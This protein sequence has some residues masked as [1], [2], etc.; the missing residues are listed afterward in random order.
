MLVEGFENLGVGVDGTTSMSETLALVKEAEDLGFHSFWLSEG[1]HSRSA[2]V[3]ATVIA[4]S[5]SRIRIGLGILSPHTKHPALLAMDAAS[6]D[7]VARGRLIL[8]VGTVKNALRKHGF[9]RVDATQVV[10]E[11]IDLL[12][13]LLS[14]QL[15][16]YE[17]AKF[18]IPSPGSRLEL[19]SPR[20]LLIYVGATG[21]A[22]LRLAGQHA[23]G[24]LFNYPCTRN[25]IKYA[26]PF[27]EEGLRLSGRT[28]ENFDVSAYLL[29]AVDEDEKRA[30]DSA[31]CFLAQKLPTR[32][33]QMLRQAGVSAEEIALVKDNV[34]R[35]GLA[36]AASEIDD[37]LV[38][39][40]AIAGTPD[41]VIAGLR[42]FFGVGLKLPV[43]WEIIGPNRQHSLSLIAKEVMPKV[44]QRR[45]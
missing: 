20:D 35:L 15:V 42:Q 18:R 8:G 40:V 45:V 6:L 32:H 43:I 28:V 11:A 17:G 10:K 9:E 13:R 29:V 3:R 1:Y 26:M 16:Q 31:K 25:F 7:E 5:T 24:V 36:R 22:M 39:K 33:S 12:K 37:A 38:R 14:G 30:L 34:D 27:V 23:D 19:D 4:L 41:Q 2:V 21:P 44:V